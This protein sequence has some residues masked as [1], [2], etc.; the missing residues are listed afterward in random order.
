MKIKINSF[1]F[2]FMLILVSCSKSSI[3]I[4]DKFIQEISKI[5]DNEASTI[6]YIPDKATNLIY[7]RLS[8]GK[9]ASTN[10]LE[11]E[12]V[13]Q[14]HYKNNFQSFYI[15]LKQVLNQKTSIN[16]NDI[17]KSDVIIFDIDKKIFN[18]STSLIKEIYLE[19]DKEMYYLYP[20]NLSLNQKQTILYKMFIDNYLI[21]FDD[22]EG[23]Y[24]VTK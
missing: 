4:N 5:N 12:N 24:I 8:D 6:S 16:S 2:L 22:Y 15:F 20:K 18:Q 19:K 23:K 1:Y 11:L 13:Y 17:S 3:Q 14:D 21:S 9:L 10:A 7:I